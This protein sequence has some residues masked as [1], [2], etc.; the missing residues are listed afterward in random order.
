LQLQGLQEKNSAK[1]RG[2]VHPPPI[3][4]SGMAGMAIG[5]ALQGFRPVSKNSILDLFF[6]VLTP[7]W[8]SCTETRL[9][10]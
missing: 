1:D 9:P 10:L 5:L 6:E 4:E 7:L 3:A 8:S 2:S